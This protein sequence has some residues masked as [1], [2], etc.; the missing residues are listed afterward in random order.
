MHIPDIDIPKNIPEAD[1]DDI[2]ENIA[3]EVEKSHA[4]VVEDIYKYIT[5]NKYDSPDG[6]LFF[7]FAI[8]VFAN[9]DEMMQG[10][11]IDIIGGRSEEDERGYWE[12][13]E[14]AVK[15][16]SV[17][18]V[19]AD[20]DLAGQ[21]DNDTYDRYNK[22][23]DVYTDDARSHKRNS[24]R[25]SGDNSSRRDSR[26]RDDRD[27]G[28]NN[29]SSRDSGRES[30]RE[31][32]RSGRTRRAKGSDTPVTTFRRSKPKLEIV[33]R[34][35]NP[36]RERPA[37][38]VD[39]N[40]LPTSLVKDAILIPVPKV[41]GDKMQY[42]TRVDNKHEEAFT[43]ES[44]AEH[45]LSAYLKE[46]DG[47]V[48]P[49]V[50]YTST[51]RTVEEANAGTMLYTHPDQF[52]V[53]V[54]G[55]VTD[56]I[57]L[58]MKEVCAEN[59]EY[60]KERHTR[61]YGSKTTTDIFVT[62][63]VLKYEYV[64][65]ETSNARL[66]TFDAWHDYLSKLD[67]PPE[68]LV[69]TLTFLYNQYVAMILPTERKRIGN[70][71]ESYAA[72]HKAMLSDADNC[73]DYIASIDKYLNSH[74]VVEPGTSLIFRMPVLNVDFASR[75]VVGKK[76]Q[77]VYDGRVMAIE[78]ENNSLLYTMFANL[79]MYRKSLN[80]CGLLHVNADDSNRL[81]LIGHGVTGS[82]VGVLAIDPDNTARP[83]R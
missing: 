69:N 40:Y 50:D 31:S 42:G 6:D 81:Y 36:R 27:S 53:A 68:T 35:D 57:R 24:Y 82:N 44:Y 71:I 7:Q 12:A 39:C 34:N 80:F 38:V 45:E 51:P 11:R 47:V 43:V 1:V 59:P 15:V 13:I 64:L 79:L 25:Y 74:I 4:R 21:L 55:N 20:R 52:E 62:Q 9:M 22:I 18:F 83:I 49:I 37:A 17:C 56:A 58:A 23:K 73:A 75:Y 10:K 5:H 2:L 14:N 26:G 65:S 19:L 70:F 33:A 54:L 30:S 61:L 32:N 16:A 60:N 3:D 76:Y 72:A 67:N 28:R 77:Y 8:N 46:V 29:R 78:Y 48:K 66:N 41:L 63:L